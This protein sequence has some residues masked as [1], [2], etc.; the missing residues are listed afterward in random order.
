MYKNV[1]FLFKGM[2]NNNPSFKSRQLNIFD[3]PNS[4]DESFNVG[5][6]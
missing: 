1:L 6:E 4:A 2:C 3:V 5:Y